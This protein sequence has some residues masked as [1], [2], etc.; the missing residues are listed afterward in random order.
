MKLVPVCFLLVLAAACGGGSQKSVERSAVILALPKQESSGSPVVSLTATPNVGTDPLVVT[1][2]AQCATCVAYAWDFGDGASNSVPGATQQHTYSAGTYNPLVVVTDKRGQ[3][4]SAQTTVTV[5]CGA[6]LS[7]DCSNISLAPIVYPAAPN[8]GGLSGAGATFT[9]PVFGTPGVRV[10]DAYFDPSA[11]GN[12]GNQYAVS[13]GGSADNNWWSTDSKL[14]LVINP[15]TWK[16]LVGINPVTLQVTRPYAGVASGC[17]R[18]TGNCS[19]YGGFSFT[20]TA[21]FSRTDPCKLY[22]FNGTT[23]QYYEFGSD[24]VP[25]AN[26]C[27]PSISGPPA[28]VTVTN[29][30]ENSPA[31]CV[32]TA[33]NVL[34]SNFGA[35]T[36]TDEASTVDGDAL[37]GSAFSS[38]AYHNGSS[39][40]QNTGCYATIWSPT[41]GGMAYNSCTG[42]ITADPGWA[43]GSGLTCTPSGCTGTVNTASRYSI[44]N[45][46]FNL[47]GSRMY[48]QWS[49]TGSCIVQPCTAD[50]PF[51]WIT[52]TTTVYVS[53]A[54]EAS[55]HWC[56]GYSGLVNYPGSPTWEFFYRT[57]PASGTPG[58]PVAL[59]TLPSGNPRGIDM[60]CGWQMDNLSDTAPVEFTTS[61]A[62]IGNWG[63]L[64]FDQPQGP[65][66]NE[67]D[68]MDTN[69]DGLVHRE[70]LTF[71]S[72]YSTTFSAQWNITSASR[73]CVSVG[74]DWFNI[75]NAGGTSTSCIPKGPIWN[76]SYAYAAGYTITPAT[77]NN[78]GGYSYRISTA[79]TAGGTQPGTWNQAV[80]GT[81]TDGGCTWT[82]VGVPSGVNACGTDVYA[83]CPP[84]DLTPAF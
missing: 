47:D 55:G 80:G 38:V 81:Q 69:G 57:E 51:V 60:H 22:V 23:V 56:G 30:Q 29:F 9:D 66:W 14:T 3:P 75:R 42:A 39:T 52:G 31:G 78:A 25:F 53:E 43:G 63:L 8:V 49:G 54:T 45:V 5:S 58:S 17:P 21:E 44:H 35:P 70:A 20:G 13:N 82:N 18:G 11:I 65:W 27:S 64:P 1:F 59:N 7:P 50:D 15:G 19:T 16:Y 26:S 68:Y 2:T 33:C 36:W 24:V 77:P 74:S 72:G 62:A 34:P 41:K 4:G 84:S 61:T 71:N 73:Q 40:G 32:N 76:A 83:W 10:T 48:L 12:S 28:P 79:C 6:S 46:K 67:I 37:V